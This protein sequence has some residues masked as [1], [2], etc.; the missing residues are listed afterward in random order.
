MLFHQNTYKT[1]N[2]AIKMSQA[3]HVIVWFECFTD[4]T[5]FKYA[6]N[7]IQNWEMDALKF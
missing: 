3:F 1:G 6:F 7:V 5:L 4:L 2:N